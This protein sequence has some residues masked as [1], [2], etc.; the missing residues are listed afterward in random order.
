[1]DHVGPI[2]VEHSE[3]G[4]VLAFVGGSV[5]VDPD[6]EDN[7]H[8]RVEV[9]EV[10]SLEGEVSLSTVHSVETDTVG[11]LGDDVDVIDN[12]LDPGTAPG[13]DRLRGVVVEAVK[14]LVQVRVWW[15]LGNHRHRRWLLWVT[16]VEVIKT[17]KVLISTAYFMYLLNH[18]L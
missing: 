11:E 5:V 6:G 10:D 18:N 9:E 4:I 2:G 8:G 12:I 15:E 16:I 17:L 14:G 7:L 1:M 13:H 3:E